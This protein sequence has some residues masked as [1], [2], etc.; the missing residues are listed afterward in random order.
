MTITQIKSAIDE[1]APSE[2]LAVEVY[3]RASTLVT[4]E[5]FQREMQTRAIDM[6]RGQTFSSE[7]VRELHQMLT[8]K[9][10]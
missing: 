7:S 10:L 5:S 9:G 6:E 1:M 2:K 4:S 8:Q 3:A